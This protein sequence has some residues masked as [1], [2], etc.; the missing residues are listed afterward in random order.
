M[1]SHGAVA[2]SLGTACDLHLIRREHVSSRGRDRTGH[3]N[4][5]LQ[6]G[7]TMPSRDSREAVAI[8]HKG[9]VFAIA[10]T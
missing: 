7:P 9:F 8:P 2:A 4:D 6:V 3:T 5:D 1:S 10:A